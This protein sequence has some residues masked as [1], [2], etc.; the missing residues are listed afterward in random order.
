MNLNVLGSMQI[1]NFVKFKRNFIKRDRD[2]DRSGIKYYLLF[3]I[4][5]NGNSDLLIDNLIKRNKMCRAMICK[6]ETFS[7]L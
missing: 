5:G 4:N 1:F 6:N 3:F 2:V 7:C